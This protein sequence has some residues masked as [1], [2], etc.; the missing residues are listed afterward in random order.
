ML[1]ILHTA[2]WHLGNFPGPVDENNQNLRFRDIC[3][4][5]EQLIDTVKAEKPDIVIIA[6]DIFHQSKTWSERGL[7]ETDTIVN[8]INRLSKLAYVCILRGTAN[9]DGGTHFKLLKT[10]MENNDNVLIV[11][12]I[13]SA[14]IDD[15]INIAFLPVLDKNIYRAQA[16]TA[17]DA[18]AENL[19]IGEKLAEQIA[20]LAKENVGQKTADGSVIPSLLVTHYTV[21]GSI[22]PN[23]Q[24]NLLATQEPVIDIKTL[25]NANFSLTCLGHIHK[26]QALASN[27]R[28]YYSGSLCQ[29]NFND[30]KDAHGFYIHEIES[31]DKINTRFVELKSRQFRTLFLDDAVLNDIIS[32]NYDISQNLQPADCI[33]NCVVRVIY[34]CT[35]TTNK[36]LNKALLEKALLTQG[37]AFYVQEIFPSQISVTVDKTAML[38]NATVEDNLIKFLTNERDENSSITDKQIQD[39]LNLAAPI[40]AA[41]NA[42]MNTAKHTGIFMPVEI[43]VKNY[44]NYRDAVF[45]YNDIKFCVI[46]GD[47]G[48]GKSSLFMDAMLDALFEEPREGELTGWINNDPAVK[49]GSIKFTFSIGSDIY[50]ITRTRLKSGKATLNLAQQDPNSPDNW[51]NLSKDKFKDTQTAINDL[52]GLD[53]K[54]LKSC[55][56]IMQDAYGFFLQADRTDRMDILANILDLNCYNSLLARVEELALICKRE[57]EKCEIEQT[58]IKNNLKDG[59]DI[60][61]R[62]DEA[63]AKGAE[64][65]AQLKA[66]Q[67]KLQSYISRRDAIYKD[68]DIY[69]QLT[70]EITELEQ[71]IKDI[72]TD[73]ATQRQI[74]TDADN[75]LSQSGQIAADCAEHDRLVE[76]EK[77]LLIKSARLDGLRTS[78]SNLQQ[79]IDQ[80]GTS[81]KDADS[82]IESFKN[83]RRIIEIELEQSDKILADAAAYDKLKAQ[84]DELQTVEANAN[85][86]LAKLNQANADMTELNNAKSSEIAIFD[87][88]IK[89][90]QEKIALLNEANCPVSETATC[91]FLADAQTAKRE[92][93]TLEAQKQSA[94]AAHDAKI[95]A[96]TTIVDNLQKQYN[97]LATQI[98]PLA[99]LR[100]QL[101]A[102]ESNAFKRESIPEK[103][104]QLDAYNSQIADFEKIKAETEQKLAA[105]VKDFNDNNTQIATVVA[106]ISPLAET[107]KRIGELKAAFV[108]R[109]SLATATANKTAAET[110]IAGFEKDKKRSEM[111]VF[112]KT[113]K[114]NKLNIDKAEVDTL[115]SNIN[116]GNA[117]ADYIQSNIDENN[118]LIGELS[119]DMREY[120][121]NIARLD[122]LKQLIANNGYILSNC[123]WLKK[124][125]NRDGIPHN[126]VRSVIPLLETKASNILNQMSGNRMS[127]KFKTEKVLTTKKEVAALDVIICDAATGDLPYLSRSGGERV[128]SALSVILALA[129]IKSEQNGIQLGFLFIDEPPFLDA[130]G[131]DAYCDALEA[132]QNRY[133][134]LKIIAVTHDIA[135]KSRF[136]QSIDVA[137]TPNGSVITPNL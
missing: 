95:S 40:I 132:I 19:F 112:S 64:Y 53:S 103:Q 124:A 17:L 82:K 101:K 122:E 24:T 121:A 36:I 123:A 47:N 41:V 105:A 79:L 31:A 111:S 130:K 77:E 1:K 3:N 57:T 30:S 69:H 68:I 23:G 14:C 38:N 43:E 104:R 8:Y 125:F 52:I 21:L 92:L 49:S 16:D 6:G 26:P 25:E 99:D 29:L 126:I 109:D 22:M 96:Q 113:G 63:N 13:C 65:A 127:I 74:I 98:S 46:N 72:E 75:L 80:L 120:R 118:R 100:L 39:C 33:Q 61:R 73:I 9:H 84:I 97:A 32:K 135:M 35:D 106:E 51:I 107:Q 37:G 12:D 59:E 91:R 114:R 119:T 81:I 7:F 86:I 102:L 117:Q 28:I 134:N 116:A 20:S 48:A 110:A 88:K 85:A 78:H 27:A 42:D 62:I 15:K 18:E 133:S 87:T 66:C 60:K 93:P 89:A 94:I 136:K 90:L 44:R 56:L 108:L 67:E 137:R 83:N 11:D 2:D 54:T 129:E 58:H 34:N 55:G 115:D 5:I 50:K 128:Q 71:R 4:C 45:N 70:D 76:I 131:A 10:V